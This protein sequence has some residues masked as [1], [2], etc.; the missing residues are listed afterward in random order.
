MEDGGDITEAR[1]YMQRGLRFCKKD[2]RIWIEYAKLEMIYISKIVGRRQILGLDN[3]RDQ[4][5][6]KNRSEELNGDVVALP[7]I[8]A[9][10]IDPHKRVSADEDQEALEKLSASPALSGA[11][12]TA[13]FDAAM[14]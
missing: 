5:V 8:T 2:E 7:A 14:K 6:A 1:S 10:D 4:Q 12:P 9:E 3:Q 13:I 11:I